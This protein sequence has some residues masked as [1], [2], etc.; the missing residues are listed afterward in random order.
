MLTSA[1][2][3]HVIPMQLVPIPGDLIHVLITQVILEMEEPVQ[4]IIESSLREW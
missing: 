3:T 4:V 2:Q 1:Q